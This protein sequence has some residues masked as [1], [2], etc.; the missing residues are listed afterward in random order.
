MKLNSIRV[1]SGEYR[2]RRI[3]YSESDGLRP[4]PDRVRENLFNILQG[5]IPGAAVLDLFSGTGAFG[6]EAL[7]RGAAYAVFADKSGECI[8]N[9]KY[10]LDSFKIAPDKFQMLHSDC[11]YALKMLNGRGFDIV[12]MDPPF[13]SGLYTESISTA[14]DSGVVDGA[15][16]IVTE[17]P[18][19][20]PFD[21]PEN[22]EVT[23]ER[24]YGTIMLRFIRPKLPTAGG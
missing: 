2:G 3:L 14:I 18:E 1:I 15:G 22:A 19:I 16:L 24:T 17:S 13:E 5:D 21:L 23:D 12:F 9:I 7:S 8:K 11:A 20:K 6:L 10:N 4:T